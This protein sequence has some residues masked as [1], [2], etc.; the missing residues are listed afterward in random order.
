MATKTRPQ[1]PARPARTI[2]ES[3]SAVA[4]R[5]DNHFREQFEAPTT[6]TEE[7]A[8]MAE[9]AIPSGEMIVLEPGMRIHQRERTVSIEIPVADIPTDGH[10]RRFTNVDCRLTEKG[11]VEAFQRLYYSLNQTHT[12]LACGKHIDTPSDVVKYLLEQ[13]TLAT[14]GS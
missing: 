4:E 11:H 9:T 14:S 10:V 12:Q 8:P 5:P 3:A 6:A 7:P 13:F 2:V 1:R